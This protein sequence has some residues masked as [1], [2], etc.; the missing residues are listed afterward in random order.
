MFP[1]SDRFIEVLRSSQMDSVTEV[2][3]LDATGAMTPLSFSSGS[4]TMDATRS[5]ARTCD[6]EFVP[7]SLSLDQLF[8]LLS[9][10]DI[11]VQVKRGITVDGVPEL[12]PLGVFSVDGVPKSLRSTTSLRWSGSDRSKKIARAR[13]TDPF[14]ILAGTLLASAIS[15]LLHSRWAL[16]TVDFSNVTETIWANVYLLPGADSD[17]WKSAREIMA[18]FG[19]DLYFD[20]AGIAKARLVPD[21]AVDP[22][23]FSFGV[24]DTALIT[25]GE[26][27]GTYER[28]YSGV[29]VTG[30]GSAVSAP[31]QAV[32]WD[33]DPRSPTYYLGGFGLAP[34]FYSSPLLREVADCEVV[35]ASRLSRVKG[36]SL[37]ASWSS[38][39]CAALEPLDVVEATFEGSL[40]RAV[41]DS[42]T[43]PLRASDTMSSAIRETQV[44]I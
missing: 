7:G 12:V 6:I 27:A 31:V 18:D 30:A 23:N 29:V 4:V 34:L 22:V 19:Y 16:V 39:V 3:A 9:R 20:G 25:E 14:Q 41:I 15:D 1:V 38:L 13:L 5:I 32:A 11:E 2:V 24:G 44:A 28:T 8:A 17:P 37:S 10:P 33:T 42:L 40:R 21:P 36:R 26:S 35:A 43:I